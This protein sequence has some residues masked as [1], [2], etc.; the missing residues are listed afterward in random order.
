MSDNNQETKKAFNDVEREKR[1]EIHCYVLIPAGM[2][3]LNNLKHCRRMEKER[4]QSHL[5]IKD[6]Q[7]SASSGNS[8]RHCSQCFPL[9]PFTWTLCSKFMF[10]SNFFKGFTKYTLCFYHPTHELKSSK[11]NNRIYQSGQF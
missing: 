3:S 6:F 7:I 2:A 4:D 1:G 5:S 11:Q 10:F 9:Q 8:E